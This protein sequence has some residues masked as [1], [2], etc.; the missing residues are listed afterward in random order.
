MSLETIYA[1]SSGAGPTG[2]AVIRVSGPEVQNIT[3]SL[4]GKLPNDRVAQ[5]CRLIDRSDNSVLD[6]ALVL[7]FKGPRSFTGEDV[8]EFHIHGGRAVISSVLS[9]LSTFVNCRMAE[10]GEFSRRGFENGKLDL[11]EVEGLA[12]LIAADTLGQKS[13]ALTQLGGE[14]S[15]LYDEWRSDL[16]YAIA[17]VESALDFSDEADVPEDIAGEAL[18]TVQNLYNKIEAFLDDGARG[19][20][21]T[22]CPL[23]PAW[24]R[25]P[26][27]FSLQA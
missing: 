15:K 12:D 11:I 20:I 3:T 1:L 27:G 7:F 9:K 5:L 24:R 21:V 18:P 19:E 8:V 25:A 14:T 22:P 26:R 17:L 4:C 23:P 16:I 2:V 13:Q 6:E 10:R